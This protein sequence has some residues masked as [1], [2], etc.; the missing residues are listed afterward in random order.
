M[1]RAKVFLALP[2]YGQDIPEAKLMPLFA[3]REHD[4]AVKPGGCSILPYTF[5]ELWCEALNTRKKDGWTHF[6]MA[7]SDLRAEKFWLDK[8]IAEQRRVGADLLSCV[9]A[10]KDENGIAPGATS[11][12]L[13]EKETKA[14]RRLTLKDI[15]EYPPTFSAP[16]GYTLCVNTGLWVCDFTQSWVTEVD[17]RGLTKVYFHFTD[18]IL[19]VGDTYKTRNMPEDWNFSMACD[20]LGVKVFATRA[21]RVEHCGRKWYTNQLPIENAADAARCVA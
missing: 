2:S 17:E 8:L 18:Y 6:A 14:H 20:K 11:T 1:D 9:I 19:K 10:I 3:S 12:A 13:I 5:N 15:Y 16:A 7:H 4:V 21:I